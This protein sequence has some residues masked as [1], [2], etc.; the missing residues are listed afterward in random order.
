MNEILQ[1]TWSYF[2]DKIN[3]IDL[4]TEI[5]LTNPRLTMTQIRKIQSKR[6]LFIEEIKSIQDFNLRTLESTTKEHFLSN[7]ET[8]ESHFLQ[9]LKRDC[10]ILSYYDSGQIYHANKN[11][12]A[13]FADR[14]LGFLI[15]VDEPVTVGAKTF[16]RS[17]LSKRNNQKEVLIK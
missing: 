4:K 13:D 9:F 7:N 15:I 1:N 6:E 10:F 14:F 11:N 5:L 16:F 8:N 17:I 2:D 12:N 3:K